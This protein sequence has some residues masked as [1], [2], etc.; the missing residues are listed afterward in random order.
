MKTIISSSGYSFTVFSTF[1]WL[2][3]VS[4]GVLRFSVIHVYIGFTSS[5]EAW[6]RTAGSTGREGRKREPAEA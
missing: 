2:F 4:Y 3:K 5:H 6:Q 1:F